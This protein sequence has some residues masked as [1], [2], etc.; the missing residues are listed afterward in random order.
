[1]GFGKG[2]HYTTTK[3]T[4]QGTKGQTSAIFYVNMTL[5]FLAQ[6]KCGKDLGRTMIFSLMGPFCWDDSRKPTYYFGPSA[7]SIVTVH[8]DL[9]DL[10]VAWDHTCNIVVVSPNEDSVTTNQVR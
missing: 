10:N 9:M 5:F 4:P 1:M 7:A 6:E 8:A 3:F 2:K